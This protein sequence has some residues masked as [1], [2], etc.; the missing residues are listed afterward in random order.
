M[1]WDDIDNII[2]DGTSEQIDSIKC[3]EC[4]GKL[5]LS[6]FPMTKSVEILCR[7]CGTIIRQNGITRTPNF[8]IIK[9]G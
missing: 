3:P 6:Y 4:N 1:G 8:A 7:G 5:K 9:A 2:Y